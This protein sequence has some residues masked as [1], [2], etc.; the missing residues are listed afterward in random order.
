MFGN[1][2]CGSFM[3]YSCYRFDDDN[4]FDIEARFVC[5]FMPL[6]EFPTIHSDPLAVA[7]LR[8]VSPLL[9]LIRLDFLLAT[10]L[11]EMKISLCDGLG[12]GIWQCPR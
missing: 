7:N 6:N 3:V 11:K 9:P 5:T 10:F 2:Q 8:N 12:K 4:L 1:M